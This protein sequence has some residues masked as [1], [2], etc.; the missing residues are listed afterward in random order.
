M[1]RFL[2]LVA[3]WNVVGIVAVVLIGG[4]VLFA[5]VRG[6][7]QGYQLGASATEQRMTEDRQPALQRA[8]DKGYGD[9]TT[10]G[11]ARVMGGY[12]TGR[13]RVTTDLPRAKLSGQPSPVTECVAV[14]WNGRGGLFIPDHGPTP[15]AGG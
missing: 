3:E 5:Y 14:H 13:C 2:Q 4:V 1:R 12:K 7:E 8:F 10:E 9:G 15:Q 6:Q 11:V